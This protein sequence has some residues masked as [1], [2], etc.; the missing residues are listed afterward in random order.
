MKWSVSY[1]KSLSSKWSNSVEGAQ[2][3]DPSTNIE[4]CQRDC[5]AHLYLLEK[6]AIAENHVA[7]LALE[8]DVDA[9]LAWRVYVNLAIGR[10]AKWI[11]RLGVE[12]E[13]HILPPLDVLLVWHAFLQH[14]EGWAQFCNLAGVPID[15]WSW[16]ILVRRYVAP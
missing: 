11:S 14:P 15:S 2:R 16:H 10:F 8:H 1:L 9:A 12:R 4:V 5:V 6:F 3:R 7:D 13:H